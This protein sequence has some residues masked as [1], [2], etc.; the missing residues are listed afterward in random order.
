[1][2]PDQRSTIFW[3]TISKS[4]PSRSALRGGDTHTHFWVP[5]AHLGPSGQIMGELVSDYEGLLSDYGGLASDY[6][7]LLSDYAG[8]LA[9]YGGLVSDYYLGL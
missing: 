6:G 8:L 1:M 7:A 5:G 4:S 2:D 3:M 9:D